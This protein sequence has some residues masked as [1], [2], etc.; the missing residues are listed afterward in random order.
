[1]PVIDL[2]DALDYLRDPA[3]KRGWE[4]VHDAM[5]DRAHVLM[6]ELITCAGPLDEI[7]RVQGKVL[8]T[9]EAMNLVRE[10]TAA[11]ARQVKAAKPTG[12]DGEE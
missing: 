3:F 12:E 11:Y 9:Q 7:A 5:A 1:M 8:A 6:A 10:L 2:E 4:I